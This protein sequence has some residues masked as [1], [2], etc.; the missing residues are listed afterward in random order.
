MK[1]Y[2]IKIKAIQ[3][4][5]GMNLDWVEEREDDKGKYGLYFTDKP[6]RDCLVVED[7][8]WIVE[9]PDGRK[10]TLTDSEFKKMV[11]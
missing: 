11:A 8:E 7:G 6:I 5:P 1:E 2:S 10:Q 3:W 4:Q 9:Y